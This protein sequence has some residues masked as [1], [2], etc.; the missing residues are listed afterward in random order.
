MPDI[1]NHKNN[2]IQFLDCTLRDGGLGIEDA[3]LNENIVDVF[4]PEDIKTVAC[5]LSKSQ[6]DIIELGSIEISNH[7]KKKF[8]IYQNIEEIS[9]KIPQKC[10]N[11]QLFAGLFRGPDTPIEDIQHANDS[12]VDVIRVILRYSELQK[13][14]DFCAHLAEKGY[15]V[16][17][18]P[19]V[20]MRYTEE[21]IDFL[22]SSANQMK[23]YALYFV[24]TY[25]YMDNNHIRSYYDVYDSHLDDDIRIGFHAHNNMSSAFSNACWF[26]ENAMNKENSSRK[27]VVDACVLGM[28][29]GAGNVQTELLANYLNNKWSKSYNYLPILDVCESIEKHNNENL[30][31]YSVTNMLPAINKVAYKYS[32]VFRNKYGFSYRKIYEMLFN[33]PEDLRH[34]Y[35][36][37][38]AKKL[39]DLYDSGKLMEDNSK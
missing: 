20:T 33:I 12:Y 7:D 14:V 24:D 21:E 9:T 25:G 30:W 10:N 11:T 8:A 16:F 22:I 36:P 32:L 23:A 15:K 1:T 3:Y 2:R 26:I 27:I 18:Q 28:G 34:R 31:G 29:Q 35:T 19:M 6:I 17:M 37:E 13:S 4:T 39:I 38:N 5:N